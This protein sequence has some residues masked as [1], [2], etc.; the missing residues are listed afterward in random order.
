ME[1][2]DDAIVVHHHFHE[3]LTI[4]VVVEPQVDRRFDRTAKACMIEHGSKAGDDSAIDE[5]LDPRTGRIW[6]Q[7]NR[8]TDLTVG[9]S[10][11]TL[12]ITEYFSVYIV[13]HSRHHLISVRFTAFSVPPTAYFPS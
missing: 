13:Y 12:Q 1:T 5:A 10:G 11:I 2:L 7:P 4:A 6:T 8:S 9:H 3:R